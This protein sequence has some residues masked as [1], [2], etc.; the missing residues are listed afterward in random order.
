[1]TRPKKKT[2]TNTSN[3]KLDECLSALDAISLDDTAP[4]KNDT[5]STEAATEQKDAA[6][7]QIV[8]EDEIHETTVS[9]TAVSEDVKAVAETVVSSEVTTETIGGVENNQTDVPQTKDVQDTSVKQNTEGKKVIGKKTFVYVPPKK[10]VETKQV[11]EEEK[12]VERV[13]V[14]NHTNTEGKQKKRPTTKEV[15]GY[16]WLGL[17]YDF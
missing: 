1:M 15:F 4:V 2:A 7:T 6:V 8:I 17:Q 9:E 3:S 16:E 14:V 10:S 11:V 12:P 13:E 5:V